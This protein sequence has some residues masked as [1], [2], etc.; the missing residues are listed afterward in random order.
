MNAKNTQNNK[1]DQYTGGTPIQG[2]FYKKIAMN[3]DIPEPAIEDGYDE[4]FST[5]N[6]F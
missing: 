2:N 6:L 3:E 1:T 5:I 4:F